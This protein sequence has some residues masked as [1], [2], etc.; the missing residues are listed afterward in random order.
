MSSPSYPEST[1]GLPRIRQSDLTLYQMCGHRWRLE[2]ERRHRSATVRM[3]IG[4]AVAAGAREDNRSKVATGAGLRLPEIVDA[5]VAEYEAEAE[6]V[7]VPEPKREV[8]QGKDA[9]AGAARVYGGEVSP[10]TPRVIE[11]EEPVVA[12]WGEVELAGQPDVI[13][14]DG[15]GDYKVGR[16]LSQADAERTHQLT[17]YGILHRARHGEWPGRVW[18]DSIHQSK[19]QWRARRLLSTRTDDDYRAFAEVARATVNDMRRGA[20]NLPRPTD[21][22]CSMRWCPFFGECKY[23]NARR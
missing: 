10:L 12:T 13:T 4:S 16:L 15:V 20:I 14:P 6:E 5:A 22:W 11:A 8:D 9:T 7:D 21:W 17:L 19:G 3:L 18:L 2:R 23:V 1:S